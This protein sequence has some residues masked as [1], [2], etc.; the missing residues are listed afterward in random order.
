MASNAAVEK[1][2]NLGLSHGEKAVVGLAVVLFLLFVGVAIGNKSGLEFGPDD[3]S[4]KAQQAETNLSAKQTTE[5]ILDK[6]VANGLK[7]TTEFEVVVVRQ[8]SKALDPAEYIARQRWVTPEPGAGLI[9]DEPVLIAPTDLY[10]FPNRGGYNLFKIDDK[11]ERIVSTEKDAPK[12]QMGGRRGGRGGMGMMGSGGMGGGRPPSQRAKQEAEDRA[13]LAEIKQKNKLVGSADDAKATEK[14]APAEAT[15]AYVEVIK[16]LRSV[17]I[18]GK[19]DNKKLKENYLTALKNP[20]LAY[21]NYKRLD[22]QRQTLGSDGVTWSD[23]QDVDSRANYRI[24]DNITEEDEE[25]VREDAILEALVDPLPFPVSGYWASV[26]VASLVPKEKLAPAKNQ[27][28]SGYGGGGDMMGS[29]GM[30]RPGGSGVMGP[31]PGMMGGM[32]RPGGAMGGSASRGSGMMG[33]AT[34]TAGMSRPGPGGMAMGGSGGGFPTSGAAAPGG[35]VDDTTFAKSEADTVMIRAI[36]FTVQ[37]GETYRYQ[38]RIVVV[39]PNKYHVDVN[40]GVDTEKDELVGPWSDEPTDA[41]TMP[42]DVSAYALNM[43]PKG[44]RDD[45]QVKFQLVRWIPEDGHTVTRTD[46]A[47]PGELIGEYATSQVPQGEGKKPVSQAVDFN[48]RQFVLDSIG[49]QL[50]APKSLKSTA[51]FDEPALALLLRPD[52]SVAVHSQASD[53]SDPVRIEMDKTYKQELKDAG[54]RR[55][56]GGG[57]SMMGGSGMMGGGRSMPGGG[58]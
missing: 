56:R 31:P 11:D 42:A 50:P 27:A 52:G 23:W 18:T 38:V 8:Q 43:V 39:N 13:K 15:V 28:G 4:K 17:V 57:M 10:A 48:S 9:R 5:S 51:P 54:R 29:A 6:L 14:D 55:P 3:L 34:G 2:K 44:R 45:P 24:L 19:L 40:P 49:G 53:I 30:S 46:D 25:M 16:G 1:L 35:P 33:P 26:H 41:V 32:S 12:R 37:P 58:R 7:P 36:D 21:P 22:V 47:G 20:D